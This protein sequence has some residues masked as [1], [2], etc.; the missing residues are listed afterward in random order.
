MQ[1]VDVLI[2]TPTRLSTYK[3][4]QFT[5]LQAVATIGEAISEY[6]AD[7]WACRVGAFWHCYGSPETT[8][9]STM[10]RCHC[11]HGEN[12]N[13]CRTGKY[14]LTCPTDTGHDGIASIGNPVPNSFAYI[15]GDDGLPRLFN[16]PGWIWIGGFGVP[17]D[18]VGYE[19][20]SYRR[21]PFKKDG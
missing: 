4:D 10:S 14:L 17:A 3:P 11:S 12:S 13:S 6:L 20:N 5:N 7:Q 16:Q 15:L 19:S 21:N 8:I 9:V 18:C 1:Q 2:T